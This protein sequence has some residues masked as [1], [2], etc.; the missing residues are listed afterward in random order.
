MLPVLPRTARAG[1][2]DQPWAWRYPLVRKT[3]GPTRRLADDPP[4]SRGG[5]DRRGNRLP[6]ISSHRDYCLSRERRCARA[7]TG[8]AAHESPRT[9]KLYDRTKERL[10]QD[11]VE[12][13]RL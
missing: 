11:E 10:T 1:C 9:T 8:M 6:H 5:W 13:I 7:C 4:P 12:R 3:H 2:S